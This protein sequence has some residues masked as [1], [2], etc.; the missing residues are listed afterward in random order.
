[1]TGFREFFSSNFWKCQARSVADY[2]QSGFTG[3][4]RKLMENV[5]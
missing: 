1:M 2:T 4:S 5:C 3:T